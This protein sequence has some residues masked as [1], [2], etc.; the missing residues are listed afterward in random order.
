MLVSYYKNT[1]VLVCPT[2]K[3]NNPLSG[4]TD[5]VDFPADCASRSYMING[6]NDYFS[7]T[8]DPATF[9]NSYMAGTWP[10]GLPS[11]KFQ[12]PSDTIIFGEKLATSPQFYVDIY[13]YDGA[14]NGND[15]T[16][17][18]QVMHITG[19]DYCFADNSARILPQ[20]FSMGHPVNMWCVLPG[21]RVL[22]AVN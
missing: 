22:N 7:N 9:V 5:P 10:D 17:L 19:S 21:P 15:Y 20:F 16:E 1:N 2:D 3:I 8:L 11:D 6:Y 13:E 18:N 12:F 4:G 14:T